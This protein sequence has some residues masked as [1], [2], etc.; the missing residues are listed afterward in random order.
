MVVTQTARRPV[1]A[2]RIASS[3]IAIIIALT[4]L[5][6]LWLAPALGQ[7]TALVN[8]FPAFVL[9][10]VWTLFTGY[11]FGGKP[12]LRKLLLLP[13]LIVS[14]RLPVTVLHGLQIVNWL[15]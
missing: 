10:S 12:L 1:V 8:L 15:M 5:Q 2:S 9:I 13:V 3:D 4:L 7:K 11:Y 6:Y 14:L